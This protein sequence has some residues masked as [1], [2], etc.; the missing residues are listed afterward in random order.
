LVFR[1]DETDLH[2]S[3]YSV[4][5]SIENLATLLNL[6]LPSD[7][8]KKVKEAK[9]KEKKIKKFDGVTKVYFE[10]NNGFNVGI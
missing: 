4:V 5:K 3:L 2:D 8:P 7:K 10:I 1:N 6:E 9:T